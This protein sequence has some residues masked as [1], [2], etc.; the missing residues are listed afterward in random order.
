MLN[1]FLTNLATFGISN[2]IV[3]NSGVGAILFGREKQYRFFRYINTLFLML[4]VCVCGIITYFLD[5][6]I[7]AKFDLYE[8]KI[9]VVILIASLYN[10]LVSFVWGKTS[11]FGHYLYEK[12]CSY[13]FDTVFTA[14]VVMTLQLTL[15]FVPFLMSLLAV[16][17]VIFVTNFIIGFFIEG[18]NKSS[19]PLCCRNVTARLFLIAIFAML[20]YYANMLI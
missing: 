11:L 12:S 19:L 13:V 15:A 18:V 8:I 20:L 16:V 17:V 10:L 5:F 6:Y 4:G 2:N 9:G 3:I 7:C 1:L 14:F